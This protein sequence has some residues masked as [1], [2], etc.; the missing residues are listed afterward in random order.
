MKFK[1]MLKLGLPILAVTS[2]ALVLPIT[3][4]S[5]GGKTITDD[6]INTTNKNYISLDQTQA[7]RINLA[8]GTTISSFAKKNIKKEVQSETQKVDKS[9]I[10]EAIKT[11]LF[12]TSLAGHVESVKIIVTDSSQYNKK[13]NVEITLKENYTILLHKGVIFNFNVNGEKLITNKPY[14]SNISVDEN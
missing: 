12:N 8:I 5:C 6:N 2:M 14:Y 11:T 1:K 10:E 7:N 3:L 13:V 9:K 4:T